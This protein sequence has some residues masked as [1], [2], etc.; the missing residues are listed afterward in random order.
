MNTKIHRIELELEGVRV[1][2]ERA[3]EF[4][5]AVYLTVPIKNDGWLTRPLSDDSDAAQEVRDLIYMVTARPTRAV[6]TNS[7]VLDLVNLL[8]RLT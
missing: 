7:E 8:R 6:A 1:I 3:A 2:V 5:D 4:S